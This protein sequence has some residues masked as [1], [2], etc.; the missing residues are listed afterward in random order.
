MGKV[1][2]RLSLNLTLSIHLSP[3]PTVALTLPLTTAEYGK[4]G[5]KLAYG[6]G[7]ESNPYGM[8]GEDGNRY[9]KGGDSRG[10]IS[11]RPGADDTDARGRGMLGGRGDWGNPDRNFSGGAK[12]G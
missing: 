6:K 12:G 10:G 4:G 1:E 9:R 2:R 7:G 11:Y 3:T 8:M 5:H